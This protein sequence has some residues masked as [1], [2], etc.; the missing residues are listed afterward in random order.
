MSFVIHANTRSQGAAAITLQNHRGM[1]GFYGCDSC[2]EAREHLHSTMLRTFSVN[3]SAV[4]TNLKH[5]A[6][7]L[8]RVVA[9]KGL[10]PRTP[11]NIL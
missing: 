1:T 3:H 6:D 7:P 10:S 2:H 5:D 11:V 9:L 4:K 8:V